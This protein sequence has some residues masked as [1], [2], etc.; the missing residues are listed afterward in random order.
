MYRLSSLMSLVLVTVGAT[1]CESSDDPETTGRPDSGGD[2]AEGGD[3]AGCDPAER[4]CESSDVFTCN[5]SGTQWVFEEACEHGCS[6][7]VCDTCAP[8]CDG[9]VCG[10]DGCGDTCGTC[11][12]AEEACVAGTCVC[13][14]VCDG[15][16][17]GDDSCGATCGACD[18][19]SEYCSVEQKC[20]ACESAACG[21]CDEIDVSQIVSYTGQIGG[22]HAVNQLR[23]EVFDWPITTDL[24]VKIDGPSP[25]FYLHH[26]DGESWNKT[27]NG[28]TD[29][30]AMVACWES[31]AQGGVVCQ[32]YEW[33]SPDWN[34]C[35]SMDWPAD[36][37][38]A[39]VLIS[40][41]DEKRTPIKYFGSWPYNN[42]DPGFDS[43]DVGTGM[44]KRTCQ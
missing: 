10:D 22:D 5:E 25:C 4:R 15:K 2:A 34:V 36:R 14:P 18:A 6:H 37:P 8:S 29:G 32:S 28:Y 16:N 12:G 9:K 13:Q 39:H 20:V 26:F 35:R 44:T 42:V 3:S 40:A 38:V 43:S 19:V 30:A 17:C 1:A 33:Y 7:G 31:V 23:A 27:S 41:I 11:G 24:E 21:A